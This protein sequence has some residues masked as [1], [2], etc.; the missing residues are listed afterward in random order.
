[1]ATTKNHSRLFYAPRIDLY[2]AR[3]AIE[4]LR[5]ESA[6]HIGN[7]AHTLN[8][9]NLYLFVIDLENIHFLHSA[10]HTADGFYGQAEI[11]ANIDSRHGQSKLCCTQF[12]PRIATGDAEKQGRNSLLGRVFAQQ[13]NE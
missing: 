11:V 1:M 7:S 10:E 13:S 5:R 4:R 8:I 12:S 6:R 3:A 2:Q 9:E